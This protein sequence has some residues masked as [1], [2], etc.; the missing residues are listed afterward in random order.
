MSGAQIACQT[1]SEHVERGS[2]DSPS[3]AAIVKGSEADVVRHFSDVAPELATLAEVN[4]FLD[5]DLGG[6]S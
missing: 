2:C 1:S 3:Q 6:G 5:L 4:A